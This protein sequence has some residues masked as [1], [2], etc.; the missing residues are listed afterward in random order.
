MM[1]IKKEAITK[2]MAKSWLG[3]VPANKRFWCYGG[4][5]LKN[6]EELAIALAEMS[7]ETFGHHV[8]KDKNDFSNWLRDVIGDVTLA[9][10]LQKVTSRTAAAR[11]V[12]TRLNNLKKKL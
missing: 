11:T 1:V 9:D 2:E 5:T 4:R 3:D 12:E 7:E 10:Q 8:T 6:L